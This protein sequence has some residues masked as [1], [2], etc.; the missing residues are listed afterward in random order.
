MEEEKTGWKLVTTATHCDRV[1]W[2]PLIDWCHSDEASTPDNDNKHEIK[3][4]STSL[5]DG[6]KV[7]EYALHH[8]R[9]F[10]G[11][12]DNLYQKFLLSSQFGNMTTAHL[13][14]H[15]KNR[16]NKAEYLAWKEK[17][18]ELRKE[19]S[20]AQ[21][22][23]WKRATAAR[24]GAGD[25]VVTEEEIKAKV[26][27]LTSDYKL[28]EARRQ[29]TR[30]V[31]KLNTKHREPTDDEVERE[32]AST[33][34][35]PELKIGMKQFRLGFC[36]CIK[37]RK[38]SECDCQLCTYVK[39]NLVKFHHARAVWRKK[40]ACA[41]DCPC[42]AGV[43]VN[44]EKALE[45]ATEGGDVG[46]IAAAE[47]TVA[48]EKSKRAAFYAA[49]QS[50]SRLMSHVLCEPLPDAEVNGPLPEQHH[51]QQ[52]PLTPKQQLEQ[53]QQLSP[54]WLTCRQA[55]RPFKVHAH[56]CLNKQCKPNLFNSSKR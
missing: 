27:M 19:A 20:G 4:H 2:G 17:R 26:T 39:C 35:Y 25:N 52:Q 54:R 8:R 24:E 9:Y 41:E 38:S 46:R 31:L 5:K 48:D 10:N 53:W 51:E 28:K 49:T 37:H 56:A 50:P 11:T 18:D 12:I 21:F 3:V 13:D 14:Y 16:R 36:N 34:D 32:V 30:K 6:A 45:E 23:E 40:K 15:K 42:P 47:A 22:R 7:V 43:L 44:A 33:P 29:A 55:K 1:D